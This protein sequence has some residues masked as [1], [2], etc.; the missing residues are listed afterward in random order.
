MTRLEQL[1]NWF[2]W[3]PFYAWAQTL[4]IVLI[5]NLFAMALIAANL[6]LLHWLTR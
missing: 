1:W 5:V 3:S 4:V 6:A 2:Y